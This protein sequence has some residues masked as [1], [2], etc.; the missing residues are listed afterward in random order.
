MSDALE[1]A[2]QT[3]SPSIMRVMWEHSA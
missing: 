1:L 3:Q 2:R